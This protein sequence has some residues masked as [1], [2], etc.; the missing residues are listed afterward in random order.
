MGRRVFNV[1]YLLRQVVGHLDCCDWSQLS[2]AA[3]P[4]LAW[5]VRETWKV[6][7]PQ[8]RKAATSRRSPYHRRSPNHRCLSEQG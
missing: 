6:A 2:F 3:E 1:L 4:L 5:K 7:P 8:N